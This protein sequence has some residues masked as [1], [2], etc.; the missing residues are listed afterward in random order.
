M[1]QRDRLIDGAALAPVVGATAAASAV[2]AE[3]LKAV[4]AWIEADGRWSRADDAIR[5]PDGIAVPL[6]GP[7]LATLGRLVAEDIL[8]MV[9]DV[10]EYRLVAGV[11]CFP[12]R[13]RLDEKLGCPLSRIHAPVPVYDETM[14][15]RV[16][17]VF[18]TLRAHAPLQRLN[19]L[20]HATDDL[21]Q[22]L[23]EAEAAPAAWQ[24]GAAVLRTERQCLWR[25][26]ASG[27]VL[28]TVKTSNT[29]VAALP[30]D[31]RTVL[32][33]EMARWDA[34]DVAYRGGSDAVARARAALLADR[35]DQPLHGG[36]AGP[37]MGQTGGDS[38]GP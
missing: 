6:H 33:A 36:A 32:A 29:P 34:A 13:W 27:A 5:R 2:V 10:P 20:V 35:F 37:M 21:H 12:S 7:P 3:C 19:W 14:A 28:F 11:L 30:H 23:G 16:N 25:L 31:Q 22:P 8:I 9:P 17:R 15:A 4:L 38:H 18:R 26:P 24:I 1:A